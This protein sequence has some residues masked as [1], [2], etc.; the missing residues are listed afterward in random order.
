[1]KE[2]VLITG[3]VAT[4]LF[5]FSFLV[6]SRT[7]MKTIERKLLAEGIDIPWW[8]EKG[9]GFRIS[10]FVS[11]LARGKPSKHPVLA[12]EL[13]L[14]H[15]RTYDRVLAIIVEISFV[16]FMIFAAIYYFLYEN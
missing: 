7:S 10:I 13:I 2:F 15:S 6:F 14:R 9:W 11:V 5:L 12:D 8:D 1:M 4:V 16:L 3:G